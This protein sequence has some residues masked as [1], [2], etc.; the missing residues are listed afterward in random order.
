[1]P[2]LQAICAGTAAWQWEASPRGLNPLDTAMNV[3]LPEFDGR[4]VTVPISFKE[5][6][7]ERLGERRGL[8]PPNSDKPSVGAREKQ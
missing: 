5:P 4:I 1:M 6:V 2:V 7:N 3:A 8:S